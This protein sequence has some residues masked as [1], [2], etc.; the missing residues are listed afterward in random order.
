MSENNEQPRVR[1]GVDDLINLLSFLFWYEQEDPGA[2]WGGIKIGDAIES[3]RKLLGFD[4]E[5]FEKIEM[6]S[7]GEFKDDT[8]NE[9]PGQTPPQV[10]TQT[11]KS[12]G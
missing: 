6:I 3:C 7:L 8:P 2:I 9:T 11:P 1:G 10:Q 12:A 4:E 5:A